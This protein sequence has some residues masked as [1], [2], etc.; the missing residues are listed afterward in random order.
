MTNQ[1][2]P[3]SKAVA[4]YHVMKSREGF[5]ETAKALVELVAAAEERSPGQPRILFLD[6]DGHRNGAG[7]LDND[8]YEIVSNFMAEMITPFLTEWSHPLGRFRNTNPQRNDVFHSV[9]VT[10]Q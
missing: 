2:E 8:A 6:I 7:G 4:I 3:D 5:D 1:P 9:T 10:E